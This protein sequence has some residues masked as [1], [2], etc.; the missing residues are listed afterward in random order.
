MGWMHMDKENVDCCN[1]I[2]ELL[3]GRTTRDAIVILDFMKTMITR[4]S[5][6]DGTEFPIV[7]PNEDS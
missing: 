7:A 2:M 6:V 4:A 3:K 1:A 5:H